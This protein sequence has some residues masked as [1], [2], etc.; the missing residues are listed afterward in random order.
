MP[1]TTPQQFNRC[2]VNAYN[3]YDGNGEIL[4]N[5]DIVTKCWGGGN[6]GRPYKGWQFHRLSISREG[7]LKLPECE[8]VVRANELVK[9]HSDDTLFNAIGLNKQYKVYR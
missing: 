5:G 4:F 9:I 1:K 2:S 6:D 8:N 3:I 7:E